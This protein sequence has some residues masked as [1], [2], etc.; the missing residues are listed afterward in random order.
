[1]TRARFVV[2]VALGAMLGAC[3]VENAPAPPSQPPV[4]TT[5]PISG[6]GP[7]GGDQDH[8]GGADERPHE[9]NPTA[10]A[11]GATCATD[12]DCESAVCFVG[13]RGGY[14]SARCA[15]DA[16]CPAAADGAQHCNP[17]GYCRY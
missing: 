14:C 12:A 1:M 15:S 11:F 13:G 9:S 6:D 16:E 8:T 10:R 3:T 5:S 2:L 7:G 17:R 4:S